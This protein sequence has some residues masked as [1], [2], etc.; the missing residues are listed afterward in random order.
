MEGLTRA[1]PEYDYIYLEDSANLPYGD[2]S[3][4]EIYKLIE[5]WCAFLFKKGC[6]LIVLACHTAS[7]H[8]LRRVQKE[9]LPKRHPAKKVLGVT[10]PLCEEVAQNRQNRLVGVLATESTCES[11]NF[12]KEFKKI[13]PS[14]KCFCQSAPSLVEIIEQE[15]L[16]KKELDIYLE[17]YLSPL[18]GKN[19]STLVL[20]CTHYAFIRDEIKTALMGRADI[21]SVDEILPFKLESYFLRHPEIERRV[22]KNWQRIFLTS[23]PNLCF[24]K[25]VKALFGKDIKI[26]RVT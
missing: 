3:Q 21:I 20:G 24:N 22:S 7:S 11:G 1:L 18:L 9:F 23:S 10:V 13:N 26:K 17:K 15:N 5:K 16:D 8:A 19:I 4:E 6:T 2:K 25:R 12:E 14:I